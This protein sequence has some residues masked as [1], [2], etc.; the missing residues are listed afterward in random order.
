MCYSI[1]FMGRLMISNPT[2][3]DLEKSATVPQTF[4]QRGV[5]V[6]CRSRESR[7]MNRGSA[8]HPRSADVRRGGGGTTDDLR[9]HPAAPTLS[10]SSRTFRSL[11]L[12]PQSA[13]P[14]FLGPKR[15]IT[16]EMTP[17]GRSRS[18]CPPLY[19]CIS[20]L[21]SLYEQMSKESLIL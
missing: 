2:N 11:T 15:S 16:P 8:P 17:D 10:P 20:K 9:L 1:T 12:R 19:V 14:L 3:A 4:T 6:H 13:H 21:P 5:K 18:D 7:N